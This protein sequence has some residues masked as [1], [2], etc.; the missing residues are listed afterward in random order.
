MLISRKKCPH[1]PNLPDPRE[2]VTGNNVNNTAGNATVMAVHVGLIPT[3]W[4]R[5]KTRPRN[6]EKATSICGSG[7]S[8]DKTTTSE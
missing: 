2:G 3:Q 5:R 4:R 8:R 1:D 6:S 7:G